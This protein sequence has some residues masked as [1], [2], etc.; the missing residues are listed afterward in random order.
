[1]EKIIEEKL[2]SNLINLIKEQYGEEIAEKIFN[3]YLKRRNVSFRVNTLKASKEEVVK[4][5]NDKGIEYDIPLWYEDAFVLKNVFEKDIECEDIYEEGKIYLQNLSSMLPPILLEPKEKKDILDMTAAPGG[6]TTE[7]AALTN[8]KAYITACEKN[9]VRADRLRYNLKKQGANAY[10]IEKDATM[11]DSFLKFDQILLDAPCS[12]SGTIILN[13]ETEN[14]RLTDGYMEKLEKVQT[15]LLDKA[16]TLLKSGEEMVYSTCS[17]LYRENEHIVNKFLNNNK[18]EIVPIDKSKF[19]G[20]EFLPC[21]FKD[22]LLVMPNENYEGF[23]AI[24]IRKNK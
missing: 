15:K 10:V 5:L 17:I 18:I 12:G 2:P 21:E 23:F 6:K 1:M 11:L 14:I 13:E 24:K 4:V 8:N 19:R 7:I 3:G 16:I 9:K 20:I 22:A